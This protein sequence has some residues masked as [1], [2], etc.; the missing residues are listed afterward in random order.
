M[1]AGI[2]HVHDLEYTTSPLVSL[3]IQIFL[4]LPSNRAAKLIAKNF[5]LQKVAII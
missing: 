3:V 2:I 4:I 5:K 1:T